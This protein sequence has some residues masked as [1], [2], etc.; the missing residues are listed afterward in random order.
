MRFS[1]WLKAVI[2]YWLGFSPS[3]RLAR[4]MALLM[5][6]R[7]E[8]I[9]CQPLLLNHTCR[10]TD[11]LQGDAAKPC[12]RSACAHTKHART[13]QKGIPASCVPNKKHHRHRIHRPWAA[14]RPALCIDL[15]LR[16]SSPPSIRGRH[17]YRFSC[18][19]GN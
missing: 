1:G 18:N 11:Q 2:P 16:T 15:T 9:A 6:F 19:L 8:L 5:T 4:R 7:K 17:G 13:L 3:C 10:E 14:T 12:P